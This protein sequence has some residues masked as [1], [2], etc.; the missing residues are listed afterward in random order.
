MLAKIKSSPRWIRLPSHPPTIGKVKNPD[1]WGTKS[2]KRMIL[3]NTRV[4][5]WCTVAYSLP[6]PAYTHTM[7]QSDGNTGKL[8]T[9]SPTGFDSI[10]V[11]E[12]KKP[13]LCGARNCFRPYSKARS[14]IVDVKVRCIWKITRYVY[15]QRNTSNIS[16]CQPI[17]PGKWVLLLHWCFCSGSQIMFHILGVSKN[18]RKC[19]S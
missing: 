15:C 5:N 8:T 4:K 16:S 14:S 12:D 18:R 13:V 6:I 9:I 10:N 1:L 17:R 11:G 19:N 3:R 2:A 7:S